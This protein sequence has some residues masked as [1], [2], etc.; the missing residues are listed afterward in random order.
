MIPH[1]LLKDTVRL[2]VLVTVTEAL[3]NVPVHMS[4][5]SMFPNSLGKHPQ[6]GLLGHMVTLL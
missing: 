2:H 5:E 1:H 4:C 3:R 6:E